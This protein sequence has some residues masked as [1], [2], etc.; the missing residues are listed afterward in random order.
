MPL[1]VHPTDLLTTLVRA[2]DKSVRAGLPEV[3]FSC[4]ADLDEFATFGWAR[5]MT[6]IAGTFMCLHI[7]ERHVRVTPFARNGPIWTDV[8]L[9]VGKEAG[10]DFRPAVQ[11]TRDFS[12]IADSF[13]VLDHV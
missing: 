6:D 4:F 11:G 3:R 2:R 8:M 9:V 7:T 1:N 5:L 10:T 13:V 12:H